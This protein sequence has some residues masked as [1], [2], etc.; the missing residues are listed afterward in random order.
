MNCI[1]NTSDFLAR[2]FS[3]ETVTF[4]HNGATVICNFDRDAEAVDVTIDYHKDDMPPVDHRYTDRIPPCVCEHILG[5]DV[6]WRELALDWKYSHW[7]SI[8]Y[9]GLIGMITHGWFID[10]Y[11]RRVRC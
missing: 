8:K 7:N 3:L 10:G 5:E 2:M 4:E 6:N 1:T 9:Q 11:K